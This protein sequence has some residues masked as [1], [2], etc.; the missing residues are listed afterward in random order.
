M[1]SSYQL[2]DDNISSVTFKAGRDNGLSSGYTLNVVLISLSSTPIKSIE[3]ETT[4]VN[5]GTFRLGSEKGISLSMGRSMTRT[6]QGSTSSSVDPITDLLKKSVI[7]STTRSALYQYVSDSTGLENRD[8]IVFVSEADR[9]RAGE[10]LSVGNIQ[11]YCG[12][13]MGLSDGEANNVQ[14]LFDKVADSPIVANLMTSGEIKWQS[15]DTSN[16]NSLFHI[17][18]GLAGGILMTV[19]DIF[20]KI[21]APLGLELYWV[22]DNIYSLEP[23]RIANDNSETIATVRKDEIISLDTESNPYNTPSLIIPVELEDDIM[24]KAASIGLQYVLDVGILNGDDEATRSLK[25]E[26]YN[27][28]SFLVNPLKNA[29]TSA[30]IARN[31]TVGAIA[32]LTT[33]EAVGKYELF[34]GDFARKTSLYER[35]SGSCVIVFRPELTVPYAWYD[36]DGTDAFVTSI[37]HTITR[38]KATTLLTIAAMRDLTKGETAQPKPKGNSAKKA[39]DSED[40]VVKE[41]VDK[42]VII[43]SEYVRKIDG[44]IQDMF[45]F[46]REEKDTHHAVL[47]GKLLEKE[48]T[49]IFGDEAK[50]DD[51]L[52]LQ[53][54]LHPKV[55]ASATKKET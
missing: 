4:G 38:N 31:K 35:N 55:A 46:H 14:I 45:S 48:I 47:G 39:K 23:P 7:M 43:D 42:S 19:E 5:A 34:Y 15:G 16:E 30:S 2:S 20:R 22:K 53:G 51:V 24:G 52:S 29:I 44:H 54:E 32:E 41:I 12:I 49:S 8:K 27:I 40:R 6:H 21:L 3:V 25:I 50:E 17:S 10:H 11:G 37:V 13:M 1:I 9:Q 18:G 26:K 28:P 36:I 33:S